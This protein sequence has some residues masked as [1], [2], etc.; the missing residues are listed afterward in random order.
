MGAAIG[1]G[2]QGQHI[3]GRT[4]GAAQRQHSRSSTAGAVQAQHSRDSMGLDKE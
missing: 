1:V 2:Q 4:A 3:S